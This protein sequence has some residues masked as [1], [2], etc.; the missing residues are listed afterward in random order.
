MKKGA[1]S[2]FLEKAGISLV[3]GLAALS[4]NLHS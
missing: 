2:A 1:R 3:D 4:I